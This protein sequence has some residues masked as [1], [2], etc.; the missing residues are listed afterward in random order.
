MVKKKKQQ[1]IDS[2]S[3]KLLNLVVDKPKNLNSFL[4]I[5]FNYNKDGIGLFDTHF[6]KT[7]ADLILMIKVLSDYSKVLDYKLNGLSQVSEENEENRY[8]G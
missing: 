6:L 2:E 5:G 7:K 8:I 1:V 4:F 3:W